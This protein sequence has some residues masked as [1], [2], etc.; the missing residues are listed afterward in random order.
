MRGKELD[1][2]QE[3]VGFYTLIRASVSSEFK[4]CSFFDSCSNLSVAVV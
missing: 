3:R 2:L 4:D 1:N